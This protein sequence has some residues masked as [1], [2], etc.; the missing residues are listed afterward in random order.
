MKHARK[1]LALGVM[2]AALHSQSAFARWEGEITNPPPEITSQFK[3][4]EV[5]A[6]HELLSD[7]GIKYVGIVQFSDFF[8]FTYLKWNGGKDSWKKVEKT[9]VLEIFILIDG[10]PKTIWTR[11]PHPAN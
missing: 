3:R 5:L 2:I 6:Y 10:E 9:D 11:S 8:V 1:L 7:S 4:G